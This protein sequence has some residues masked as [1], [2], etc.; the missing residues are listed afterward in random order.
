MKGNEI[1]IKPGNAVCASDAPKNTKSKTKKSS[2]TVTTLTSNDFIIEN[3]PTP[4]TLYNILIHTSATYKILFK[5]SKYI[6]QFGVIL[7]MN[8]FILEF[9]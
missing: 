3:S 1:L 8:F 4:P 6:F 5:N 2:K 9:F 7:N